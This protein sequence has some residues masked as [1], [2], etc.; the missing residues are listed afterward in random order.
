MKNKSQIDLIPEDIFS[1][2][3]KE[4][5]TI[6]EVIKKMR[7]NACGGSYKAVH[8]RVKREGL[9]ISHFHTPIQ[10]R[11]LAFQI[12]IR[13]RTIPLEDALIVNS[14]Y[15]STSTLKRRLIAEGLLE[16]KC[17]ICGN[18]GEHNG[19]PLSLQIDHKNGIRNDNRIEN[20]RILCPNC[21]TQ[22]DTYAGRGKR[23]Q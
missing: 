13:K 11:R 21:H 19:L 16:Y 17:E 20:L 7:K 6:S 10:Q 18:L 22:T 14:T 9:D 8:N 1:S 12:A 2:F 5:N 23:N 15:L 3:I 4:S